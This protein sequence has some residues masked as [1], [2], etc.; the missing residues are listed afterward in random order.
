MNK[1]SIYIVLAYA[2]NALADPIHAFSEFE[3]GSKFCDECEEYFRSLPNSPEASDGEEVWD[4]YNARMYKWAECHPAGFNYAYHVDFYLQEIPI[5]SKEV[6]GLKEKLKDNLD[7]LEKTHGVKHANVKL[8]SVEL[9][10][11][12]STLL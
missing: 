11:L 6:L 9:S 1:T 10:S 12:L 4:D 5:A 8:S 7:W 2:Q 3:E